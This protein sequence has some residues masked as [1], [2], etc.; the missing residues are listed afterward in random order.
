MGSHPPT[1]NLQ[2]QAANSE[3]GT[4]EAFELGSPGSCFALGFANF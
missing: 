2:D 3:A 1:F 4:E